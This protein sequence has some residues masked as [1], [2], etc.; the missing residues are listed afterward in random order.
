[1]ESESATQQ[2]AAQAEEE[3][4]S[5]LA[6]EEAA[7]TAAL[8]QQQAALAESASANQEGDPPKISEETGSESGAGDSKAV[9]ELKRQR[10]ARQAAEERESYWRGVAEGRI[11]PDTQGQQQQQVVTVPGEP[12]LEDFENWEGYQKALSSFQWDQMKKQDQQKT[13]ELDYSRRLAEAEKKQP[14]LTEKISMA[15]YPSSPEI[16]HAIRDSESGPLIAGYLADNPTE[17]VR[18]SRLPV[19]RALIEIG[20]IDMKLNTPVTG[21]QQPRRVTQAPAPLTPTNIGGSGLHKAE[22]DMTTAEFIAH[23]NKLEYGG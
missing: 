13:S 9:Q 23:R 16:L 17:S 7:K 19:S 20:K 18:L 5:A 10:K 15:Q 4:R 11:N 3:A 14:G 21:Q 2:Q 1:M 12:R 6:T 8:E 22:A